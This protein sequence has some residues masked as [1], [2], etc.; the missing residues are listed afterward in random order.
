MLLTKYCRAHSCPQGTE[1]GNLATERDSIF[2]S[3]TEQICKGCHQMECFTLFK[4]FTERIGRE[5]TGL[6]SMGWRCC[7]LGFHL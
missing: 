4:C 1:T 6:L 7:K 2:F 5:N 3:V